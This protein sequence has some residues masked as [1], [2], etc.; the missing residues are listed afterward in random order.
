LIIEIINWEG[1]NAIPTHLNISN[2]AEMRLKKMKEG[3]RFSPEQCCCHGSPTVEM[4]K[5]GGKFKKGKCSRYIPPS[6]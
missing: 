1:W 5:T 3:G 6:Q 4:R 2:Y